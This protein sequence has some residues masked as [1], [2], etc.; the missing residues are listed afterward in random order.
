MFQ[1]LSQFTLRVSRNLKIIGALALVF[2]LFS[3]HFCGT[4]S[5]LGNKLPSSI[6]TVVFAVLTAYHVIALIMH[7]IV[8]DRE[9]NNSGTQYRQHLTSEI[10]R[11]ER[12]V[13][14]GEMGPVPPEISER[15]VRVDEAMGQLESMIHQDFFYQGEAQMGEPLPEGMELMTAEESREIAAESERHSDLLEYYD[16]LEYLK[17]DHET[18]SLRGMRMLHIYAPV[19]L[20]VSALCGLLIVPHLIADVGTWIVSDTPRCDS[21]GA[22]Q[23][24]P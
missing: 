24:L 7:Y 22:I 5:I 12:Q 15:R 8:D 9:F 11:L 20:G 10:D 1:Y 2:A 16:K 17:K 19:I 4:I 21:A 6:A 3:A 13:F 18:P 14:R 23:L